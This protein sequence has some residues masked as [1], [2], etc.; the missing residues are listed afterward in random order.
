MAIITGAGG[1]VTFSSGADDDIFSWTVNYSVGVDDVTSF[2]DTDHAVF[3]SQG[4]KRWRGSYQR[5]I[6][7]DTTTWAETPTTTGSATFT[8]ASGRTLSGT[9]IVEDVGTPVTK[10]GGK[11]I[12]TV[13]FQGSGALTQANPS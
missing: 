3:I 6:N 1:S 11:V 2:D 8:L 7:D 12:Q 5:Y 9:I 10:T 4:I 13:T